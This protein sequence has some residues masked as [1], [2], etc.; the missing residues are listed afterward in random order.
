MRDII[1]A[2]SSAFLLTL[3]FPKLD[4]EFFAWLGLVPLLFAIKDKRLKKAFGLSL[5]T[6]LLFFMGIFYWINVV[7]NFKF[8]DYI[9]LCTYFGLY[10]GFFG[11]AFNF[12]SKLSKFPSFVVAPALWV[13]L[14]YFRS[15]AG[16]LKLPW[17][18]LGYSQYL[19]LPMIQI[20]SFTGVYGISFLIVMVNVILYEM[21]QR[22]QKVF[23]LTLIILF[24]VGLV[25]L[26]GFNVLSKEEGVEKIN[27]TVIQG[28]IPQSIKWRP[29]FQ[30]RNLDRHVKLTKEAAVN[31]NT[32]LI[33][34]PEGAIQGP[35]SQNLHML[36][37]LLNLTKEIKTPILFGSSLRPKFGSREF[38]GSKEFNS[39]FLISPEGGIKG[40]YNK[41]YLLPFA[42]Y[43][44]YKDLP[45]WPSRFVSNASDYIP[46][47]KYAIMD[48]NSAKFGVLICWEN[49]FPELFRQFVNKGA[50]F[51][52]NITNEAWFGE[53][54]APYQFVSMSVFRAVENRIA[55]ARSANTGISCFI[56][57][58]GRII[59]KVEKGQRDVFVDG[60]LTKAIPISRDKT[61]Y[62]MY[63]DVF[64]YMNIA[65]A[66][67][68]FALSFWKM[69]EKNRLGLL[70]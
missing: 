7:S 27:V 63:G 38:R 25:I 12:I 32:S 6:G 40:I 22:R 59:G 14:E 69:R 16:F 5:L 31:D 65:G 44:P 28:N 8:I 57:P 41:M 15:H 54:A 4:L 36:E 30:K 10:I 13:S 62:T 39:A 58:Y 42:E 9:L 60:Y 66:L 68:L 53:T 55:I 11:L 2:F 37:N 20:S 21:L 33:I 46:G 61:F 67:V 45:L 26:Y 51:M 64:V 47:D 18:L 56:D 49:I 19:N 23:K 35:L 17:A 52:V 34:W 3:S 48:L 24:S 43:L 29:E 50:T 70:L 1:L